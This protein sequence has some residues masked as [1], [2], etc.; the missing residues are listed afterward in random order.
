MIVIE[1]RKFAMG[2]KSTPAREW[3]RRFV[4]HKMFLLIVGGAA[5][6]L[7]RYGVGQWFKSHPWGQVFPFGT[8]IINVI[9]SFILAFVTVV[10]ENRL[11]PEYSDPTNLLIC[12]GF[13]GGFTTFSTFEMET[14]RL[15][16]YGS[17]LYALGNVVG[18]VLAGFAGVVLGVTLA[19]FF[20]PEG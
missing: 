1:P 16:N 7:L 17:W 10:I 6:T 14:Y 11:R 20:F 19:H 13:C 18:S 15:I 8:L 12:I 5:G 4:R 9:G 2:N 3:F